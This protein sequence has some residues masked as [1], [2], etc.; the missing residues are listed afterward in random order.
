MAKRAIVA[1]TL[2]VI[3]LLVLSLIILIPVIYSQG[4]VV[5]AATD[6]YICKLS[7][8]AKYLTTIQVKESSFN[9]NCKTHDVE[10]KT[11]Y[12]LEKV[13]QIIANE[14]RL[15]WWQLGEGKLDF[16]SRL[17]FWSPTKCV[18]CSKITSEDSI[19]VD[20][21]KFE[22]FLNNNK[23]S[24]NSQ[25][26]YSEYFSR[27]KNAKISYGGREKILVSN[28]APLYV[29]F[30]VTKTGGLI[31]NLWN[32]PE[33]SG[34][35]LGSSIVAGAKIGS[36]IPLTGTI[37]GAAGGAIFGLAV[38][39]AYKNNFNPSLLLIS[40]KEVVDTCDVLE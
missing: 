23:V 8:V 4:D 39:Q 24:F 10:I 36:I 6:R 27:A 20:Q 34:A 26:T 9:L 21:K 33:Y 38:L 7:A 5:L 17:A 3:I 40:G 32:K 2:V 28:D 13:N 11:R 1:G 37:K 35:L 22:D 16:Y 15:C 18:I 19:E 29:V 31:D 25:N 12:D 30:G 14:M